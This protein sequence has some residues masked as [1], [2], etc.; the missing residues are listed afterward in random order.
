MRCTAFTVSFGALVLIATVEEAGLLAAL[1]SDQR[2]GDSAQASDVHLGHA[3]MARSRG[4]HPVQS[5]AITETVLQLLELVIAK[6]PPR[7]HGTAPAAP[8]RGACARCDAVSDSVGNDGLKH[9]KRS[10]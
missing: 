9:S 1:A 4:R 2:V 8:E 10:T 7:R 3:C 5:G 6:R